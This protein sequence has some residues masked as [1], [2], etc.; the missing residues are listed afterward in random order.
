MGDVR[1]YEYRPRWTT[2]VLCGFFFAACALVIGRQAARNDRGLILWR[3][4]ELDPDEATTFYWVLTAFSV[5][6][7]AVA[8]LLAYHWTAYRQR[9]AFGPA[10]LIVPAWRFSRRETEIA[11]ADV[12]GLS[13]RTIN[14]QRFL[15]VIHAGGKYTITA[16]LLPSR[17]AFDEVCELLAERVRGSRPG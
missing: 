10:A 16:S 1:E 14:G 8:A 4:I 3:L 11:Y 5:G 9:L 12:H 15:D 13:T 7:V 2:I 6:F 17:G